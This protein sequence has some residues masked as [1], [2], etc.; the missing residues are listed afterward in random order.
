[1]QLLPEAGGK[2]EPQTPNKFSHYCLWKDAS[3]FEGLLE[4]IQAKASSSPVLA[5]EQSKPEKEKFATAPARGDR[6]W[7]VY[8]SLNG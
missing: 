8:R 7:L 4:Q 5:Q 6:K 2:R 1:M 3:S